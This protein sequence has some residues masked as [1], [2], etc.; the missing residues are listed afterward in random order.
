MLLYLLILALGFTCGV[1]FTSDAP[2]KIHRHD[3]NKRQYVR[4]K[5]FSEMTDEELAA[6]KKKHTSEISENGRDMFAAFRDEELD[7]QWEHRNGSTYWY[8]KQ[9]GTC[10]NL[11]DYKRGLIF[12]VPLGKYPVSIR[13][14][15]A[16]EYDI[17]DKAIHRLIIESY[18]YDPDGDYYFMID[19]KLNMFSI[20][21]YNNSAVVAQRIE[22]K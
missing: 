5:E 2:R 21:N 8:P 11:K 22:P 9:P 6:R 7:S 14:H 3:P 15:I 1:V 18:G 10:V 17:D 4:Q 20:R 19:I 16:N 13:F 12:P